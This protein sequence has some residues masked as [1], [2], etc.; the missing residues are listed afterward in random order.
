MYFLTKLQF[1]SFYKITLSMA[2][3]TLLLMNSSAL[4]TFETPPLYSTLIS[5]PLLTRV[6]FSPLRVWTSLLPSFTA[7]AGNLPETTCLEKLLTDFHGGE[8]KTD[9]ITRHRAMFKLSAKRLFWL[10]LLV[11][12]MPAVYNADRCKFLESETDYSRNWKKQERELS[13]KS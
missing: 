3:I 8:V 13:W 6:I 1:A 4:T 5:W 9:P 10:C 7:A 12:N 2:W 11:K